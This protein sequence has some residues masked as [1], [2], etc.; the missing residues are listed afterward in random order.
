MLI[1]VFKY[2]CGGV[3]KK[4]VIGA[5]TLKS[6]GWNKLIY[7]KSTNVEMSALKQKLAFVDESYAVASDVRKITQIEN[8]KWI[9]DSVLS[10]EDRRA[11]IKKQREIKRS[12]GRR[13]GRVV[14][15]EYEELEQKIIDAD[16]KISALNN[17][18]KRVKPLS[19]K[20]IL[21]FNHRYDGLIETFFEALT[22]S[23]RLRFKVLVDGDL[24]SF[25]ES[26][27]FLSPTELNTKLK[28]YFSSPKFSVEEVICSLENSIRKNELA[29]K[30]SI[31]HSQKDRAA[32]AAYKIRKTKHAL[33][34]VKRIEHLDNVYGKKL[35]G[36]KT[37]IKTEKG[38]LPW[39]K[40]LLG[41]FKACSY[42]GIS[43]FNAILNSNTVALPHINEVPL[44]QFGSMFLFSTDISIFFDIRK[45]LSAHEFNKFRAFSH[46]ESKLS[47]EYP[48]KNS[49]GFPYSYFNI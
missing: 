10:S 22:E 36:V 16:S 47:K 14:H 34:I 41:N 48:V 38:E 30:Q 24:V 43:S 45:V 9:E 3:A 11:I 44:L 6:I 8:N 26:Q 35:K 31:K 23:E 1:L 12:L 15:A 40:Y 2:S 27:K 33:K 19:K 29:E 42:S 21:Q 20:T 32:L 49:I 4:G 18:Y 25:G 28:P 37:F 39:P 13:I 7:K 17:I 46:Y 5:W